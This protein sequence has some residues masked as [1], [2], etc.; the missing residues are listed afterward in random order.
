MSVS[1][2]S[3]TR[4]YDR[5]LE[6]A[7]EK[8]IP[9]ITQ[10]AI[11]HLP[12]VSLFT[13]R[14]AEAMFGGVGLG[15]R[16]K[17]VHGSGES[18]VNKVRLGVNTTRKA[19]TG[20]YDQ[21]DTTPSDTVRHART[22]WKLYGDTISISNHE[23][24]IASGESAVANIVQSEIQDGIA[25]LVDL[26][27]AHIF[28]GS[29]VASRVT[30]LDTIISANDT[31]QILAGGTYTPWNCRGISARGTAAASVS[32][33]GASFSTTGIPNWR[34]A[35]SNCREGT[36]QPNVL[37]T[38]HDIEMYY[39]GSLQ[40]QERFNNNKLAD[41]GF[42]AVQFKSAPVLAD[43]H[44]NSGYTYFLNMD[45]IRMNVLSGADFSVGPFIEPE[46][47]D[48][49]VAKVV[50]TGNLSTDGR[51]FLNKVTTQSA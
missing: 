16:G 39:E 6:Y 9:G 45:H 43:P 19:L 20:H 27:G 12:A 21:F 42:M 13:G 51:K 41:A 35:W 10:N 36:E 15:G 32:F 33:T 3:E 49:R 34:T 1:T 50:F 28:D 2:L 46:K 40:P 25:S 31:I 7:R 47:Q 30:D 37:L 5:A 24:R 48:V 4:V 14:I 38:T 17:L 26:I 8:V 18:I 23:V 22:N 11:D 44:C 29:G